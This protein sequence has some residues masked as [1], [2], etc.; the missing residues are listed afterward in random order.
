[1]VRIEPEPAERESLILLESHEPEPR[2]L[3]RGVVVAR[4]ADD[5]G[6]SAA[7]VV[8][9]DR[10]LFPAACG[11][12]LRLRIDGYEHVLVREQDVLAAVEDD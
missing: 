8:V 6:A 3:R 5:G 10:V 7:Q 11:H 4:P 12:G 9:G 1:M 2:S